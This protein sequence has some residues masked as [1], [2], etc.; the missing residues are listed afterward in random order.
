MNMFVFARYNCS[1]NSNDRIIRVYT[2]W[3]TSTS[4][5]RS[6][7]GNI[8]K[9]RI[10]RKPFSLRTRVHTIIYIRTWWI[11]SF[12]A[13]FRPLAKDKSPT[14]SYRDG[15]CT[16]TLHYGNPPTLL[17]PRPITTYDL[18]G[19]QTEVMRNEFVSS[20][21][22]YTQTHIHVSELNGGHPSLCELTRAREKWDATWLKC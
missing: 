2:V 21:D 4:M 15:L 19:H 16:H 14:Q 3:L 11:F 13:F 8:W 10:V 12:P 6:E 20:F 7:K 18:T 5:R 9:R 17:L 1:G 22:T